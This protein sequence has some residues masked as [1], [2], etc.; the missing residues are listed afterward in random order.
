M[1]DGT[2]FRAYVEEKK[3]N[4]L[5]LAK[6]LGMSQPNLYQLFKSKEFRP[7]TKKNIEK[8]LKVK[9]ADVLSTNI[10]TNISHEAGETVLV[11]KEPLERAI[12]TLAETTNRHSIIDERNSRNMERLIALLERQYGINPD[13]DERFAP[14]G[15]KGSR[16]LKPDQ[17]KKNRQ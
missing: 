3:M 17:H 2:F 13:E 16:T 1:Q 8:I 11:E 10:S 12:E 4:K 5:K 7:E 6:D 9:W 15:A 14:P